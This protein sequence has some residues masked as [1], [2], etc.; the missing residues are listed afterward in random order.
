M[1]KSRKG[2]KSVGPTPPG[3]GSGLRTEKNNAIFIFIIRYPRRK[4][5]KTSLGKKGPFIKITT[6]KK[7]V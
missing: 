7:I 2:S 4:E 5:N 1:K 3:D 6:K